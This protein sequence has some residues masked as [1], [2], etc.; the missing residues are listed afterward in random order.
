MNLEVEFDAFFHFVCVLGDFLGGFGIQREGISQE[1]AGIN[2][3]SITILLRNNRLTSCHIVC[4]S[5]RIDEPFKPP[6]PP[7]AEGG[8][9]V[10]GR[11]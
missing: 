11:Q 8:L 10:H 1:I 6:H 7:P 4:S 9:R 3:A 5:Y 2:T